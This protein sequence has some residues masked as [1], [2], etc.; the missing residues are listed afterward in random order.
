MCLCLLI[1]LPPLSIASAMPEKN[2]KEIVSS[3]TDQTS[4]AVTIYNQ[5]LALVRDAREI[6]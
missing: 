3:L 2:S 6:S 1:L 4:I 5:D